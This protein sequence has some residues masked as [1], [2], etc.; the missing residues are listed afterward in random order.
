MILTFSIFFY[1]Y[2]ISSD[3]AFRESTSLSEIRFLID[4]Q[5]MF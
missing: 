2:A 3:L 4:S 1:F 5:F